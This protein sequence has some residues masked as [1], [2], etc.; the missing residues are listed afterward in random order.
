MHKLRGQALADA[1]ECQPWLGKEH[2]ERWVKAMLG[3]KAHSMSKK[4]TPLGNGGSSKCADVPG[5]DEAAKKPSTSENGGS[6]KCAD[7]LGWQLGPPGASGSTM[8]RLCHRA[9]GAH[10]LRLRAGE[11]RQL[12]CEREVLGVFGIEPKTRDSLAEPEGSE[13]L[14]FEQ[15]VPDGPAVE[16]GMLEYFGI[17]PEVPDSSCSSQGRSTASLSSRRCS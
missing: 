8:D 16:P 15:E 9:G 2:A 4:G 12:A 3:W 7:V 14:V 5:C 13:S 6:S 10:Q 1:G 17:G 11:A